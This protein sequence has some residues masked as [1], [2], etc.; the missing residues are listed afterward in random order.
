MKLE[1]SWQIKE[2]TLRYTEEFTC[3]LYENKQVKSVYEQR[4]FML[5]SKFD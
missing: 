2:D 1:E 3:I 5:Q 4:C